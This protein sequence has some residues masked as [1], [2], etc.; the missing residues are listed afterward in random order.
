[1]WHCALYKS[2]GGEEGD[3]AQGY[4]QKEVD[5]TGGGE[6]YIDADAGEVLLV[7]FHRCLIKNA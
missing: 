4:C 1:M 2:F 6:L 3:T 5:G 7:L